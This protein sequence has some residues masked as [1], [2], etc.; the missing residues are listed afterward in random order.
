MAA[1]HEWRNAAVKPDLLAELKT[2]AEFDA[3]TRDV[4]PEEMDELIPLV[5][6]FSIS[7][8]KAHPAV[9]MR[10]TSITYP[11]INAGFWIS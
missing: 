9:L 1:W 8:T 5:T 4:T 6:R 2:P 10:S 11:G 3:E 7:S